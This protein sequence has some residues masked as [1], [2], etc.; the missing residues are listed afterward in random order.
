ML[1]ADDLCVKR[2]GHL[3]L[4]QVTATFPT[5]ITVLLGPNGAGKSSMMLALCGLLPK[6]AGG[7]TWK[8]A[9]TDHG[10]DLERF[11]STLGWMPQDPG[12]P[13]RL[14]V[15]RFLEV[16]AWLKGLQAPEQADAAARA[17]KLVDLVGFGGRTTGGLSGGEAQRVALAASLVA[18]PELIILDEPTAGFDP[19]QRSRFHR[20]LRGL[21]SDRVVLVSTH[22]LEDVEGIADHVVV[23]HQGRCVFSGTIHEFVAAGGSDDVSLTSLRLAWAELIQ[24]TEGSR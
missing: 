11:R 18:E 3:V 7:V 24:P 14:R 8:G 15:D 1:T 20:T 4:D 9:P 12:F 17:L 5:G 2:G 22:L 6:A 21:G 16:A 10:S 13:P 23:I 19:D